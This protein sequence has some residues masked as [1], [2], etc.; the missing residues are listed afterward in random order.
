MK[1]CMQE[2]RRSKNER[3]FRLESE[4]LKCT[5]NKSNILLLLLFFLIGISACNKNN[6]EQ[7]DG[8]VICCDPPPRYFFIKFNVVDQQT[9][10]D[11]FFSKG[12]QNIDRYAY[13]K[14]SGNDTTGKR[15]VVADSINKHFAIPNSQFDLDTL[16]LLLS[17]E[18]KDTVI[19]KNGRLSPRFVNG[20]FK[21]TVWYRNQRFITSTFVRYADTIWFNGQPA[22]PGS[23]FA[24]KFK[25]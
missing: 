9:G 12:T 4:E 20:H 25:K 24:Y 19:V 21:D 23:N 14:V 22:L 13:N 17:N 10:E 3:H 18:T 15:P 5:L 2:N 7:D 1:N 6:I 11:L 16:Y 8:D